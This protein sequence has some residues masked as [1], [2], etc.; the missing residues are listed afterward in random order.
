MRFNAPQ[1]SFAPAEPPPAVV[2]PGGFSSANGGSAPGFGGGVPA[3]AMVGG[4]S[5]ALPPPVVPVPVQP[6]PAARIISIPPMDPQQ[7]GTRIIGL[8]S[9]PNQ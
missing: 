7:Q 3:E 5:V 9:Q 2:D 1:E 6:Q 8:P 4:P